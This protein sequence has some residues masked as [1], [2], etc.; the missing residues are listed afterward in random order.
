MNN[1]FKDFH[2]VKDLKF[3]IPKKLQE[4][5]EQVLKIKK[6]DNDGGGIKNFAAI[7]LNQIPGQPDSIKGN[8]ARGIFG[9][10]QIIQEKNLQEIKY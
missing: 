2:T 4:G 7:C 3:D 9:L 8:N 10:N 1:H 6:Y 5:L